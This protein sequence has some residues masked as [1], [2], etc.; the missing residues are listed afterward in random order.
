[1]E[2][3]SRL[4]AIVHGY[5]Q[6]VGFRAFVAREGRR[7]GV[8]GWGENRADGAV[9]VVAEGERAAVEELLR[10]LKRGPNEAE[11]QRVEERW[12]AAEGTLSGFQ[13]RF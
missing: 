7:L 4:H 12:E 13:V 8:A 10:S 1:M 11:V 9:E 2:T 3:Q 5:V 6:G